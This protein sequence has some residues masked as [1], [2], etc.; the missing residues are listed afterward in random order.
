[1]LW[2]FNSIHLIILLVSSPQPQNTLSLQCY[3][4]SIHYPH[5]RKPCH[6]DKRTDKEALFHLPCSF[7]QSQSPS[8]QRQLDDMQPRSQGSKR[9][10]QCDC[11][12]QLDSW[13]M[14]KMAL[15]H[16]VNISN[17]DIMWHHCS[18]LWAIRNLITTLSLPTRHYWL[19][20][21][22]SQRLWSGFVVFWNL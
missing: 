12:M 19:P 4:R 11:R 7:S 20:F 1:M 21:R 5:S 16:T 2:L 9:E 6:M 22:A 8:H 3:T 10:T 13:F 15:L 17:F 18:W 14:T